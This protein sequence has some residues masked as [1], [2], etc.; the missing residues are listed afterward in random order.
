MGH[1]SQQALIESHASYA[2]SERFRSSR[3]MLPDNALKLRSNCTSV[4]L[5]GLATPT[6]IRLAFVNRVTSPLDRDDEM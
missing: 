3:G 4:A 2:S 1:R 6:S 5:L